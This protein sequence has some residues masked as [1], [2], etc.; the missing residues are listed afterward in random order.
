MLVQVPKKGKCNVLYRFIFDF[1][2]FSVSSSSALGASSSDGCAS[3]AGASVVVVVVGAPGRVLAML[4]IL[5][6]GL[7]GLI[8]A[9]LIRGLGFGVVVD[10]ASGDDSSLPSSSAASVGAL[11]VVLLLPLRPKFGL[12]KAGLD[13]DAVLGLVSAASSAGTAVV[14][15]RV[16][17]LKRLPLEG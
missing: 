7:R 1:H 11:V 3:S 4:P 5:G 14:L 2:T 8:L 10:D 15:P 12:R 6:P 9:P 13:G 17:V 16:L